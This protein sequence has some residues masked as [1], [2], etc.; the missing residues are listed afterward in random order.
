MRLDAACGCVV[1]LFLGLLSIQGGDFF[2]SPRSGPKARVVIVQDSEASSAFRARGERI[3]PI[4][5]GVSAEYHPRPPSA[6]AAC[7]AGY[8]LERGRYVLAVGSPTV[9]TIPNYQIDN[10]LALIRTV[11]GTSVQERAT[12]A[13]R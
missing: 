12:A 3:R 10:L 2:D 13:G 7:L 8:G 1:S 4:H 6:T 9:A 11:G 5:L